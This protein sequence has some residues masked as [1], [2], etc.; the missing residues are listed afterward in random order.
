M[1]MVEEMI[2]EPEVREESPIDRL[3]GL[4]AEVNQMKAMIAENIRLIAEGD[5]VEGR[6]F[7][8]SHLEMEVLKKEKEIVALQEQINA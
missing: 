7:L 2:L 8:K 4:K 5:D 3:V 1:I 6:E